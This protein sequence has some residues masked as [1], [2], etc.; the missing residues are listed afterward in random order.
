MVPTELQDG[1]WGRVK[2]L[3]NGEDREVSGVF[4]GAATTKG[5]VSALYTPSSSL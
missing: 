2:Y 4:K 5:P 3:D 1:S